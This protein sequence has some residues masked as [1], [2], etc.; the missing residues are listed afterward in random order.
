VVERI[1]GLEKDGRHEIKE[2]DG[3]E[4]LARASSLA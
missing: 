3:V 1:A 4:L 2:K